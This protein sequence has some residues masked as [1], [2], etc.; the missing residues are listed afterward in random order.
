MSEGVYDITTGEQT[1]DEEQMGR[2]AL[3]EHADRME[4]VVDALTELRDDLAKP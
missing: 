4:P 3:M 2:F 1:T